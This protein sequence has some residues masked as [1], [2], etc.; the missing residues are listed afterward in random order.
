MRSLVH[1]FGADGER[2]GHPPKDAYG[3]EQFGDLPKYLLTAPGSQWMNSSDAAT[4]NAH[5]GFSNPLRSNLGINTIR[6]FYLQYPSCSD[7]LT[8]QPYPFMN[9]PNEQCLRQ[10][11]F[12]QQLMPCLRNF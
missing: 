3:G 7:P 2:N 1:G 5:Y 6:V 11:R 4:Y 8:G 9:N 12:V 10:Q